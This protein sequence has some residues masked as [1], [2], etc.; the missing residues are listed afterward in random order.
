M[1]SER[2]PGSSPGVG[3]SI[4]HRDLFAQRM[5]ACP[6][7]GLPHREHQQPGGVPSLP[8]AGAGEMPQ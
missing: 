7:A 1:V 8:A 5:G 3:L 2:F 6:L 4:A